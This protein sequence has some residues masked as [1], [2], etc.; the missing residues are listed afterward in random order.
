[1]WLV[2]LWALSLR[3]KSGGLQAQGCRL[4]EWVVLRDPESGLGEWETQTGQIISCVLQSEK[5]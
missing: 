1:M 3:C 5:Q 2:K 4:G